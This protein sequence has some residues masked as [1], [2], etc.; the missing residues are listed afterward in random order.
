LRASATAVAVLVSA[1][2][3][4]AAGAAQDDFEVSV[5]DRLGTTSTLIAGRPVTLEATLF[6]GYSTPGCGITALGSGAP[7]SFTVALP[8]GV[9]LR[10]GAGPVATVPLSRQQAI[11]ASWPV[12]VTRPGRYRGSVTVT[13]TTPDGRTCSGAQRFRIF[14][15]RSGPALRV[16]GALLLGDGVQLAV[17]ARLPGLPHDGLGEAIADAMDGHHDPRGADFGRTELDLV[18]ALVGGRTLRVALASGFGS[19]GVACVTFARPAH[20]SGHRVRYRLHFGWNREKGMASVH[21]SGSIALHR[22][23]A[24]AA[25]RSCARQDGFAGLSR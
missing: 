6:T 7:L 23:P 25:E 19:D 15:A 16:A 8:P 4:G 12:R 22:R 11:T 18:N 1:V 21:R 9:T 13:A 2:S 10:D 24:N 14:A 20:F 3:A 5:G 17:S